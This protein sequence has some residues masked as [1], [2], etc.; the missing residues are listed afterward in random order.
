[1]KRAI[2]IG[3]MLASLLA[4]SLAGAAGARS[5]AAISIEP[6]R[7]RTIELSFD[8]YCDGIT[9]TWDTDSNVVTGVWNSSCASCPYGDVFGGIYGQA[10]YSGQSEKAFTLAPQT[11]YGGPASFVTSITLKPMGLWTMRDFHGNIINQGTWTRCGAGTKGGT[12][13]AGG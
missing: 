8:G 5:Q 9:I 7:I 4:A 6:D 12:Q 3:A 2:L 10:K 13:P 11:S 1:M